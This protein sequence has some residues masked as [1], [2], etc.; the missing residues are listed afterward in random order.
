MPRL[1]PPCPGIQSCLGNREPTFRRIYHRFLSKTLRWQRKIHLAC[2]NSTANLILT[3]PP[4]H[5]NLKLKNWHIFECNVILSPFLR[6]KELYFNEYFFLT[7]KDNYW[8]G[9]VRAVSF[10]QSLAAN[11]GRINAKHQT[12][13]K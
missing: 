8:M 3:Q 5:R 10:C 6:K 11:F 1:A 4:N 9:L 13:F 7:S 12:D 2:Y